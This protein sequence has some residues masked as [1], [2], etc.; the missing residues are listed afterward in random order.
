MPTSGNAAASTALPQPPKTS[1]NVPRP[2]AS[3]L[4][5]M[6]TSS[7]A[8]ARVPLPLVG[9]SGVATT[10]A[11]M[12][13]TCVPCKAVRHRRR[14]PCQGG[15][16]ATVHLAPLPRNRHGS[17]VS[18]RRVLIGA[19]CRSRAWPP[20]GCTRRSV[21]TSVS[22][23]ED[24]Q[25]PSHI[26]LL[27]DAPSPGGRAGPS[28]TEGRRCRL[29]RGIARSGEPAATAGTVQGRCCGVCSASR[30]SRSS[31]MSS[32]AASGTSAGGG[33]GS[34]RRSRLICLII[35]KITKARIRKFS[36]TVMK[37]P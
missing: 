30:I 19:R 31:T 2:S 3:N 6:G 12:N 9:G 11:C 13:K 26:R 25:S 16:F 35:R 32:G 37:L 33:L 14:W 27:E 22:R 7:A 5:S 17:K 8:S 20:G 15:Q 4:A 28:V 36:A 23:P 1:Q 24:G 18:W 10:T 34:S 21:P 29:A